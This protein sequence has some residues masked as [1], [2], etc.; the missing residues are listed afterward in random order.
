[1]RW[2]LTA[3][4]AAVSL[5]TCAPLYA[6][7]EVDILELRAV[8]LARVCVNETSWAQTDDCS[9]IYEVIRRK[10][11]LRGRPFEV[12]I[13]NHNHRT[14]DRARTHRRWIPWLRGDEQPRYWPYDVSWEER[15]LPQWRGRLAQAREIVAG[16]VQHRCLEAPWTWGNLQDR[17]RARRMHLRKIDC[18]NTL[19]DFYGVP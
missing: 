19:N 13:L 16:I 2:L 8:L 4:S 5:S 12:F 6:S 11:T 18:G 9:A 14:M 1:M 15:G 17:E 7:A 3:L 10:A